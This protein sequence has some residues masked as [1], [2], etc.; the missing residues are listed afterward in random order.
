MGE[1]VAPTRLQAIASGA[2][3]TATEADHLSSCD[4]CSTALD[5][6]RA[7]DDFLTRY[8]RPTGEFRVPGYRI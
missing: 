8:G 4:S 2:S 1:H 7:D 3:P 6:V 5:D